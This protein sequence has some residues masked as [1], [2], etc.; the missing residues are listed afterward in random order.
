MAGR[1]RVPLCI[2]FA[3]VTLLI[4]APSRAQ[5]PSPQEKIAAL[6]QSLAENQAALRQYSWIETTTV[7]LKGEVKKQEQK[8][9]YYGADGKVQKTPV[10][11]AAAPP[12]Q[13]QKDSGRGKRGGRVKESIVEN[14]V[15]E[16]KDY[17]E[18]AVALVHQ[19]VPPDPQKI[20]AAQA[21]GHVSVEPG[22]A[23]VAKLTVKDYLKPGDTLAIGL[24]TAAKQLSEFNV[25]SYVDKPKDDD[26]TLA[27][28]F[29]RLTDGT[30]FP[31][32]VMLN[33][34]GKNVQVKIANSGHKKAGS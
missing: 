2:A 3:G 10:P 24:D 31:Q 23:N 9:C 33:V 22:A 6:K 8:Q 11:G 1:I 12:P 30:S 15:E 4:A 13:Q 34:T 19:Y 32:Q 20:Q 21:A 27:V 7:S 26:L 5:S 29:G 16:M 17:M 18:R 28:T 25:S 14:K